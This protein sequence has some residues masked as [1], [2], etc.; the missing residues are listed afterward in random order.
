MPCPQGVDAP[1]IFEHYNDAV[2][3]GD[4][5][6]SQYL[7]RIEGHIIEDCNECGICAERCG[8]K[9]DIP[10]WLKRAGEVLP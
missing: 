10:G 7:Y 1:R 5:A 4:I 9:L 6:A 2:I 8:R 3:Y